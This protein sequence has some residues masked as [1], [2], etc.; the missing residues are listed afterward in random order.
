MPD[1]DYINWDY[2]ANINELPEKDIIGMAGAGLAED[3]PKHYEIIFGVMISCYQDE[4]G[5]RLTRLMSE[6]RAWYLPETRIQ[7]Y[8]RSLDG[9][10]AVP[11]TWMVM[12]LPL[13]VLPASKAEVRVIRALE[14]R[15]LLDPGASSPLR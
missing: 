3:D 12:T 8:V 4:G 6:L 13:A 14:C 10:Q 15:A 1:A 9:L 2:H 5:A 11:A 7:V